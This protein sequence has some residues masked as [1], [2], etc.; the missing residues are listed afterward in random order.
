MK[1]L[2]IMLVLSIP[3]LNIAIHAAIKNVIALS[4]G[5]FAESFF[6]YGFLLAFWLC[7]LLAVCLLALYSS[8]ITLPRAILFMGAISILGGSLFGVVCLGENLT[9]VEWLLFANLSLL[10]TYRFF[11][12]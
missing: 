6:S 2:T 12:A 11:L 10:I 7:A 1:V 8:G 3:V 4:G 5:S 9:G